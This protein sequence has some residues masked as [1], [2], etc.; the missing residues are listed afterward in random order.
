MYVSKLP[1]APAH[2]FLEAI[3][4]YVIYLH[5]HSISNSKANPID[6]AQDKQMLEYFEQL[7]NAIVYELY[8]PEDL[9][10]HNITFAQPLQAEILPNL[11]DIPDH[12]LEAIRAVCDRLH[13]PNH[14]IQKNL[15]AIDTLPVIRLIEGKS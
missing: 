6:S 13:T 12:K 10:A 8:L 2:N 5:Q 9:H 4:K 15:L 3:V 14:P 11:N 7:I 1:I